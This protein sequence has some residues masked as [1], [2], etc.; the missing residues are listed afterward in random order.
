MISILRFIWWTFD[1]IIDVSVFVVVKRLYFNDLWIVMELIFQLSPAQRIIEKFWL[2]YNRNS[3]SRRRKPD[4]IKILLVFF[5][6]SWRILLS[7]VPLIAFW[8]KNVM[9][10]CSICVILRSEFFKNSRLS[11]NSAYFTYLTSSYSFLNLEIV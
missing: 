8:P 2:N 4:G 6:N 3:Y 10:I 7:S 1:E 11:S 9:V 5:K